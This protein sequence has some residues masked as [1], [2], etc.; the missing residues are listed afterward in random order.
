MF[1]MNTHRFPELRSADLAFMLMSGIEVNRLVEPSL[2][3]LSC[4]ARRT[5]FGCALSNDSIAPY[6]HRSSAS[7]APGFG[8][9]SG[10]GLIAIVERHTGREPATG[11]LELI[12]VARQETGF[13]AGRAG[14]A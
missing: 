7:Q 8:C 12:E 13:A 3:G 5:R 1:K 11:L 9:L 10:A 4:D 6:C 14:H 2:P